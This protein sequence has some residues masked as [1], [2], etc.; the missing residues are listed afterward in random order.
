MCEIKSEYLITHIDLQYQ[1]LSCSTLFHLKS[2]L[3]R[4]NW[5][6]S[7]LKFDNKL[8]QICFKVLNL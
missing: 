2:A 1:Q 8:G 6:Y 3:A 4:I 5:F 7:Q